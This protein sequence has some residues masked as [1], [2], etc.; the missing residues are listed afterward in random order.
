[1]TRLTGEDKHEL[2]HVRLL[3][4]THAFIWWARNDPSLSPVAKVSIGDR[5]NEVF[6]SAV[7]TWEM[8]I[9]I[10][11]GKLAIA[12]P[13][14]SFVFSQVGLYQFHP[15]TVTHAYTYYVETMPAHHN[16]PF[17]RLLIAQAVLE[18]LVILTRDPQFDPYGVPVLW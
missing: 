12:Q 10:A 4:D 9:K 17:D 16:D 5:R 6:L 11:K 8:A 1:M 18:D 14:G 13:L 3:L 7:S 15:L 2:L